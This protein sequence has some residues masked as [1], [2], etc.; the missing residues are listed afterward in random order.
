VSYT[1]VSGLFTDILMVL[2]LAEL[3][4]GSA[5]AYSLYKPIAENDYKRIAQL[6]NFFKKAYHFIAAIIFAVGLCLVPLLKYIVKDV[7]DITESIQL[8]FM[9][10]IINTA[11]TYLLVY[12]NTLLVAAQKQY[13]V[14]NVQMIYMI[15]SITV[16]CVTLIIFKQFL[17]YL[18]LQIIFSLLQN[19]TINQIA[20]KRYPQLKE[21]S[22]ERISKE[23]RKK[24]FT[25]VRALMM[26]K[27]A[28][29]I[30]TGTDSTVISAGIG[31]GQVGILGNYRALRG[32]ATTMMAQFY[33]SINPSLGNLAAT[34]GKERQY[35]IFKKLNFGTFWEACFCATCF[36]TLFNPF[37]RIWL[38]SEKWILSIGIVAVY[39]SEYF[40]T[41]M[42]YPVGAVRLANGLFVQTKYV[43]LI[44]AI[45]NLVISI[46][47]V[48]PLGILGVILGTLL[49][50][51]LTQSWY[52]PIVIYKH[53]FK[54]SVIPYYI[55][56]LFFYGIT[57]GCCAL[58]AIAMAALP[59]FG[60]IPDFLIRLVLC[61]IVP[62]LIIT[63]LF[64]RT[65]EY[66]ECLA[67]ISKILR[68][69]VGKIFKKK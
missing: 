67:L 14:S 26:Y 1:G 34:E 51:L 37:I 62:N 28:S 30:T 8:I 5:I 39:V 22:K 55:R 11:V 9:L 50:M 7:P 48:K 56:L 21:Y 40:F 58:I 16:Q 2:S 63:V 54:R 20:T 18:V 64:S 38:G 35:Q 59:D 66:K 68:S 45:L 61:I 29:V 33:N 19:L 41:E 69:T 17:L 25:D 4:I 42:V 10:Y 27:I 31:T 6:M 3:G 32:Y 47:L 24:L 44:K 53:V 60:V 49:S 52:E 46:A 23:D 13:I 36:F 43:A 65:E 15:V 12:K 57:C